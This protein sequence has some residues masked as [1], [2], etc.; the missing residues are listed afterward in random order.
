MTLNRLKLG[1]TVLL[2]VLLILPILIACDDDEQETAEAVSTAMQIVEPTAGTTH[3]QIPTVSPTE[4]PSPELTET[5]S[6][7]PTEPGDQIDPSKPIYEQWIRTSRYVEVRDGTKLAVDIFRPSLDGIVPVDEPLPV[8]FQADPYHRA[9]IVED[10]LITILDRKPVLE[11]LLKHGYVI[12][13][14]DLR[15]SGASYGM[16][17]EPTSLA[18]AQDL[19]DMVE[20][21]AAQPWCDGNVGMFGRSYRAIMQYWTATLAPPHLKAL[22]PHMGA[23]DGYEGAY[24]GGILLDEFIGGWQMGNSI[25]DTVMLAPPVDED[26]DGSMLAEA[27]E[28]HMLNNDV[29]ELTLATPYRNSQSH[30]TGSYAYDGS[31]AYYLDEIEQSGVA[32]YHWNGW[33]DLFGGHPLLYF[34][35]VNNPQKIIIGPWSHMEEHEFDWAAEHLRWYDYW[36]KGIDNGIMDEPSIRY[37]VMGA[38]EGENW[39]TTEEWP[40]PNETPTNYYFTAG[41]TG[42]VDSVNDGGLSPEPPAQAIGQDD[43]VVDYSTTTDSFKNRYAI[44]LNYKGGAELST[45]MTLLD[46]KGLTYTTAP[47]TSDMEVTGHPVMHLCIS[48]TATDGDFFVYLEEID[49]DGV[50]WYL[51]EGILRASHRILGEPEWD[52]MGLPW[53]RGFEEDMIDLVPGEPSELVFTMSPTSNIFDEGNRIRITIICADKGNF[54]TPEL[55]PPPTISVYHNTENASYITLPVIP[56]TGE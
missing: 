12:S 41:P 43:Y 11:N 17:L 40:L 6:P 32:I 54:Q 14:L 30:I 52:N 38:P 7:L 39:R 13:C 47:L 22:S 34:N 16:R 23:F 4:I 42:S 25:L 27:V 8:V 1:P 24:Q 28:E 15:G 49:A 33:F 50:S 9:D 5:Q 48:S 10:E 45:D 19:Y 53:N 26:T 55:S 44:E 37:Y 20:W 2:L 29:Y 3:Q 46:A 31:T 35:N 21:Y 51:T 36:L 56:I 18:E